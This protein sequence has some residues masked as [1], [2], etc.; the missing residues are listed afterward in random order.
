[1]ATRDMRNMMIL[2]LAIFLAA[3]ALLEQAYGNHGLWAAMC[4]FFIARGATFAARLPGIERRLF[5]S[6]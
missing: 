1:M 4:I 5:Q 6:V 3:W 2:S